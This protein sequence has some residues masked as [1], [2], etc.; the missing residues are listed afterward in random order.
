MKIGAQLFT[1]RKTCQTIEGV[2]ETFRRIKQIGYNNVQISG[3]GPMAAKDI[4]HLLDD[5]GLHCC[6]THMAWDR[7]L[8]NLDE[9][10]ETHRLWKCRHPAIGGLPGVY[11][12]EE[13]M[14]RFLDELRPVASKLAAAGMDFSYHNHN[15]EMAR[16]G[17]A[18]WL[19]T[20]Y[21]LAPPEIL[22]AEIDTYW[23]QAGGG[24]PAEWITMQAGREPL[25]HLKDMTITADRQQRMAEIGEGNLNWP[26]ILAAARAGGVEFALVEQDDTYG[27]DPFECLSISCRNLKE[28]GASF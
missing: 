1:C 9:V 26:R 16:M 8:K 6:C 5:N 12:A 21:R 4:A 14:K 28:M 13:G 2:A 18:S 27:R 3:F 11:F 19:E 23:I 24:D 15:H 17:R 7:F 22:K 25:L 20:L 10:I